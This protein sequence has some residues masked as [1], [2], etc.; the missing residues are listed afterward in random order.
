MMDALNTQ[1]LQE[2]PVETSEKYY[3]KMN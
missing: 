2:K 1:N 3:N